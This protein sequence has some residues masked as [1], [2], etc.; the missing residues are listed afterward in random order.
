[1]G[2]GGRKKEGNGT[3]FETLTLYIFWRGQLTNRQGMVVEEE[4]RSSKS[5]SPF[6]LP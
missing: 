6:T 4:G 3:Y 1:M 2:D 5:T